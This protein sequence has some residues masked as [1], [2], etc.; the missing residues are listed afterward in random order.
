MV[1]VGW[2]CSCICCDSLPAWPLAQLGLHAFLPCPA[3]L[4][5]SPQPLVAASYCVTAFCPTRWINVA[6]YHSYW[7][8]NIPYCRCWDLN[9]ILPACIASCIVASYQH[10][11]SP[12]PTQPQQQPSASSGRLM[13][14]LATSLYGSQPACVALTPTAAVSQPPVRFGVTFVAVTALLRFAVLSSSSP[15]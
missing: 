3:N 4:P 1:V 8:W 6:F 14:Q 5:C 9:S 15:S 10:L 13:Q 12:M 2:C 11:P 7:W